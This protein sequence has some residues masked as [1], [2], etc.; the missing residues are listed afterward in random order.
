[1]WSARVYS[2]EDERYEMQQINIVHN[3]VHSGR[4][5]NRIIVS[6]L[7]PRAVCRNLA[8]QLYAH[9]V[10]SMMYTTKKSRRT[11]QEQLHKRPRHLGVLSLHP[12]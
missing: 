2:L 11:F 7:V 3:R 8:L 12:P 9:R 5:S 6:S 10:V 4:F 1:M